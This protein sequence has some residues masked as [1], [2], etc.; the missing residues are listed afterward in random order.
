MLSRNMTHNIK[1]LIS[2]HIEAQFKKQLTA[3]DATL[4]NGFDLEFLVMQQK[5]TKVYGFDIQEE[6]I[7]QSKKRIK[8]SE[9]SIQWIHD[10]HS[11]LDKYIT[12]P[13]DIV[14]FNLGYL[15]GGDKTIVTEHEQTL[16]AIKKAIELL[17]DE[18]IMSIMTYPGHKEGALEDEL[19][20]NYLQ[21]QHTK[22]LSILKLSVENVYKPCPKSYLIIKKRT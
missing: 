9:K 20:A 3:L 19:I 22:E 13:L 8:D 12:E 11:N 1:M 21:T 4:G 17:S 16:C 2:Q 6:A 15:P 5:I 10:T 7:H 18:G 14:L